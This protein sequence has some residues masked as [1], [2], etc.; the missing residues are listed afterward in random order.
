MASVRPNRLPHVL[1]R[2]LA[3][4]AVLAGSAVLATCTV[5][6]SY[7]IP[8]VAGDPK[9]GTPCDSRLGSYALPRGY[10]RI[11]VGLDGTKKTPGIVEQAGKLPIQIIRHPDPALTFCADHVNS[12]AADDRIDMLKWPLAPDAGDKKTAKEQKGAFLGAVTVNA[13]D[14]S[15][16]IINSLIRALFIG[17][18]GSP[19]FGESRS[20]IQSTEIVADLEY[21]PFNPVEA[22]AVN[23]RLTKLG[24]C[25]VLEGY[26]FD[27]SVISLNQYCNDPE[28]SSGAVTMVT[29]AYMRVV[30][31][32]LSPHLAGIHYRPRQP[33]RLMTF[34]RSDK[35]REWVLSRMDTVELENL[36]PV[37]TLA[38]QRAAFA[39][40][41]AY[42][43]FDEGALKT[44]CL[45]KKSEIEG[46][47]QIPLEISRSLLEL[48]G[49][50]FKVQIDQFSNLNDLANVQQQLYLAQKAQMA[51]A[52]SGTY[53]GPSGTNAQ[54]QSSLYPSVPTS[55][56]MPTGFGAAWKTSVADYPADVLGT[57]LA[58]VCKG[59][60]T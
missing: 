12:Y 8:A 31:Q 19:D 60:G 37:M 58:N 21:D 44:A 38:I 20:L 41:S 4:A 28:R 22:A 24:Y 18:S 17:L 43:L 26:S 25:V 27:S 55:Y 30:D 51:A 1:V 54:Y 14:Q 34:Q 32:P 52:V 7:R 50:I 5:V 48:P 29:K 3:L 56:G 49:T 35:H 11:Q 39:G 42:F 15:V 45:S 23:A 53:T 10:L 6:E 13:T 47:V 36:S 46:F 40:R 57:N 33:Y 9:L 16:F 2:S 59:D